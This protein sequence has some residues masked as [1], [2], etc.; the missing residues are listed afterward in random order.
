M[1]KSENKV[2]VP[3]LRA[4]AQDYFEAIGGGLDPALFEDEL[5]PSRNSRA[6]PV[7]RITC[8]YSG[9]IL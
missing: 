4:K 3:Y 7:S 8:L 2:A 9:F 6:T 1:S 5:D